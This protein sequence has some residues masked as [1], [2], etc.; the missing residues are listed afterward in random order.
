MKDISIRPIFKSDQPKIWDD[1]WAVR[2]ATLRDTYSMA[3]TSFQ[4]FAA[5]EEF[6]ESYRNNSFCFAFAAYD[7]DK[8]VGCVNGD[9]L[10]GNAYIRHL[11]V[12]HE[13]QHMRIGLRL[14]KQAEKASS[15]VA[16]NINLIAMDQAKP[17]YI[18]NGYRL[19]ETNN[20][21]VRSL[22]DVGH[23]ATIPVFHC[24]TKLAK[25][26]EKLSAEFDSEMINAMDSPMF[27]Y[28]NDRGSI[29][30]FS[31]LSDNDRLIVAASNGIAK[32]SVESVM[33]HYI[34][35]TR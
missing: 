13:Y 11:Y 18:K 7:G 25:A 1:F 26:C 6:W 5:F 16:K 3:L 15:L 19:G 23:L 8:V 22:S 35:K 32:F 24:T 28:C 29:D 21:F 31:V 10:H 14:L 9:A 30:G 12:L 33:N 27:V 17:F 34:N 4:H 2:V 20:R